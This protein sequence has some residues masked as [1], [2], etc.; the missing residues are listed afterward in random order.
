MTSPAT[1]RPTPTTPTATSSR[2]SPTCSASDRT[3][4]SSDTTTTT[5][6]AGQRTVDAEGNETS[7]GYDRFGN[8]TSTVDA[9]GNR[10][11][12]AYTAR[13]MMAEVRLRD[14]T[15]DP[16]ARR[17]RTGDYLVLHSYSYDFAGRLASDTDAMGR[18]VEYQ[19]YSDDLL[20]GHA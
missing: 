1:H 19:Y 5:T 6:T 7:Y 4:V 14:W 15:Q 20:K 2:S 10:Y 9:N 3:R 13:N 18:R 16:A 8:R 11:D 12:Y 17:H